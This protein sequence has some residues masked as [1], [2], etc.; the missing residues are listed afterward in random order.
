MAPSSRIGLGGALGGLLGLWSL[1]GGVQVAEGVTGLKTHPGATFGR[2]SYYTRQSCQ[3]EGTSGVWT[4]NGEAYDETAL[5]AAL[6][7][8]HFG[9]LY[10]VCRRDV[11]GAGRGALEQD[12]GCVVVRHNDYGPGRGPRRNG[13]VIDLAPAAFRQLA[14]LSAGVVEVTVTPISRK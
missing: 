8:H 6:P 7:H 13:V 1:L 3:R 4:A 2:A 9:G 14:P 11:P 10:R 5:T 12:H